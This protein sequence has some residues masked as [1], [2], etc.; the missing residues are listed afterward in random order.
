MY[1]C[2][3]ADDAGNTGNIVNYRLSGVEINN[4]H[5]NT[6]SGGAGVFKYISV[7]MEHR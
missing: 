7:C 4:Y 1:G 2:T 5:Y 3:V 6:R